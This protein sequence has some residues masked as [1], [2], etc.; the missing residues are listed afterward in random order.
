MK[1]KLICICLLF[2]LVSSNYCLAG[3]S[4]CGFNQICSRITGPLKIGLVDKKGNDVTNLKVGQE[5]SHAHFKFT[6]MT[7]KE[8]TFPKK[9]KDSIQIMINNQVLTDLIS[10]IEFTKISS[11]KDYWYKPGYLVQE[12]YLYQDGYLYPEDY[13]YQG[14][15][16]L[17]Y[18]YSPSF[19]KDISN[20]A[21]TDVHY[22]E[23]DVIL[24]DPVFMQRENFV[25]LF[26]MTDDPHGVQLEQLHCNF[27]RQSLKDTFYN[28]HGIVEASL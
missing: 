7:S 26:F 22:Y 24:D 16:F 12:G 25:E 1:A 2:S 28:I 11:K 4:P 6:A 23:V 13:W 19:L 5:L 15:F 14:V 18:T 8:I 21:K 17:P 10:K 3:R 20:Q 9:Y 27:C